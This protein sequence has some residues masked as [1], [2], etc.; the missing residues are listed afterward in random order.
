MNVFVW[1]SFGSTIKLVSFDKGQVVT[2]NGKFICGFRNSDYR[3]RSQ[4]DNTVG[5]LQGFIIHGIEVFKGNEEVTKVIDV[6]NWRIDNSWILSALASKASM[7]KNKG[8]ITEAYEWDEEEVSSY[9][10]EMVEVKVLMELAEDNDAVSKE[11]ARNGE[12]C[13]N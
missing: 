8:L 9:E 10:N 13:G 7:V 4:S 11:C 5:N 2:F 1:I 12:W 6:K 3:T